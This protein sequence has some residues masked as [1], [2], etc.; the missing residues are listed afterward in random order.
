MRVP[1]ATASGRSTFFS[2]SDSLSET[3]FNRR[4]STAYLTYGYITSCRCEYT[5]ND[6]ERRFLAAFIKNRLRGRN[7]YI[8]FLF[9][10]FFFFLCFEHNRNCC[11]IYFCAST[12]TPSDF[13]FVALIYF[14]SASIYNHYRRENDIR[15]SINLVIFGCETGLYRMRFR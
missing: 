8:D 10:F 7:S 9:L 2:I 6:A 5:M 12:P 14:L 3:Q 13:P 11:A 15:Q 4:R 1:F